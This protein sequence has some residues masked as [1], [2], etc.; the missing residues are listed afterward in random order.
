MHIPFNNLSIKKSEKYIDI[1]KKFL[2]SGKFINSNGVKKFENLFSQKFGFRYSVGCNSGTDAIE[3]AL[4]LFKQ[5][6]DEAAITVSHTATA[7]VSAIFRSGV[8]PIFCD[9]E[10]D[11]NTMCPIS[12]EKTIKICKKKKINLRY[13]IPVHIYGQIAD[14]EKINE[15]SKK[16]NLIII[17]DC[18][19]SHGSYYIK[20]K[21]VKNNICVFSLYPTKNLGAL[22][23]AGIVCT[24][25]RKYYSSLKILREYGWVD[26]ICKNVKGI[27]SRL[28]ELQA[29]ILLYKLEL[30]NKN[31]TKRQLIAKKYLKEISNK[32]IK[33]PYIRINTVHAFHLFVIQVKERNRFIKF[34]KNKKIETAIHYS[35][36]L[37]KHEGFAKIIKFDKLVNTEKLS[38]KIVSLPMNENLTNKEIITIIKTINEFK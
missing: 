7:T 30:F 29:Y 15:I 16:Y 13:I 14:M 9:I 33:L 35:K 25:N 38:N 1:F 36:P 11:F 2:K 34:L 12:L 8:R 32:K 20:N 28:D 22:G 23:D 21:N 6:E 5:R 17:E 37:H 26:R 18:S 19:Q 3:I 27:N 4:R 10:K 24:N 31:F